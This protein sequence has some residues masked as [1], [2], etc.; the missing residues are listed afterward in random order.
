MKMNSQVNI[1]LKNLSKKMDD[2][3]PGVI[4]AL[5]QLRIIKENNNR[6]NQELMR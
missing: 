4:F 6:K 2:I 3:M 5:N 1:L